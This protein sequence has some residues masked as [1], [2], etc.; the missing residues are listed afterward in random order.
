MSAL[1]V[2]LA[3]RQGYHGS[4]SVSRP[5]K[6]SPST[7]I[8]TGRVIDARVFFDL[9]AGTIGIFVLA[10]LFW[11]AGRFTR[12]FNRNKVVEGRRSVNTRYARTWY[13]WVS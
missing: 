12:R 11:K 6:E 1:M 5:P 8:K 4:P 7:P 3:T 10:V 13:G 9:F 2:S